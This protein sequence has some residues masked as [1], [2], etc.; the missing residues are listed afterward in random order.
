[1]QSNSQAINSL[2]NVQSVLQT[3]QTAGCRRY[4]TI[5]KS[6]R[7]PIL[8]KQITADFKLCQEAWNYLSN[9]MNEMA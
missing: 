6:T 3:P 5:I 9:Q 8:T 4:P 7:P 2:K 1:M